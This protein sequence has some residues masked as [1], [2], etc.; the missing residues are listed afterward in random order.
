MAADNPIECHNSLWSRGFITAYRYPSELRLSIRYTSN[1]IEGMSEPNE[2][3]QLCNKPT[4][5]IEK[6]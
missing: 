3:V 1:T 2:T 4:H 6:R 5:Y